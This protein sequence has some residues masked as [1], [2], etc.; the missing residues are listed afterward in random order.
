MTKV[1]LTSLFCLVFITK[2]PCQ[3]SLIQKVTQTLSRQV[4]LDANQAINEKPV[5]VTNATCI[6]SKGGKHDFFS[7][8]D[9]WWPD[10]LHP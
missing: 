9:Y 8:G 1:I 10:T 6:R 4:L 7:E 5:T 3:S 2:S